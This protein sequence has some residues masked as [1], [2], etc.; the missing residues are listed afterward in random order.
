MERFSNQLNVS[1]EETREIKVGCQVSGSGNWV[2]PLCTPT[3]GSISPIIV[4]ITLY[5]NC[6][7]R[8]SFFFF[9]AAPKNEK[10]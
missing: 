2:H 10:S 4:I 1:G 3:D 6:Y 5:F 8:A 9:L 7:E